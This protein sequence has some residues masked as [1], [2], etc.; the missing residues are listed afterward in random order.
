[1]VASMT[2]TDSNQLPLMSS[3]VASMKNTSEDEI[4]Q[5]ILVDME[6]SKILFDGK[7]EGFFSKIITSPS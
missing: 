6:S 3:F 2:T 1:M 7:L 5:H 4:S